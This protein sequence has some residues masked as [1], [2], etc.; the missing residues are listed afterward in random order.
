MLFGEMRSGTLVLSDDELG[1]ELSRAYLAYLG[2][3]APA[4]A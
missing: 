1:T 2:C 4:E 3:S